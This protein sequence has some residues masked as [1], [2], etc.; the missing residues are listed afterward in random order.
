MSLLE[1]G[2]APWEAEIESTGKAMCTIYN[3]K[4]EQTKY[5]LKM[6]VQLGTW[7]KLY[8]S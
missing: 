8:C 7:E 4:R 5:F 3:Q 1:T 2:G 6:L